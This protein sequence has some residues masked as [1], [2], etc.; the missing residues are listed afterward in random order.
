MNKFFL[1]AIALVFLFI[2]GC[3][4]KRSGA[5]TLPAPAPTPKST[6]NKKPPK[7]EWEVV[8]NARNGRQLMVV[9]LNQTDHPLHVFVNGT[10]GALYNKKTGQQ[11]PLLIEPRGIVS[12]SFEGGYEM[13]LPIHIALKVVCVQGGPSDCKDGISTGMIFYAPP[14]WS[15]SLLS[16]QTSVREWRVVPSSFR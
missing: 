7:P 3:A 2:G 10:P 4:A 5:K 6:A 11:R 13:S 1:G 9:I 16:F 8:V 12:H 14:R 15:G